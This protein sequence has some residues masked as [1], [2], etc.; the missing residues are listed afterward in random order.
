LLHLTAQ[1]DDHEDFLRQGHAEETRDLWFVSNV[2]DGEKEMNQ[3]NA[4]KEPI[5]VGLDT[6]RY[7]H[8]VT[9]LGQDLQL[10][11][12]PFG[13]CESQEG[14]GQLSEA[15][16]Q[17]AQQYDNVHFHIRIDAAGQYSANLQR[18]LHTLDFPKTIS[19]GEPKRNKDYRNVHFPKRKADAVESHACPRFAVVER[20]KATPETPSEYLQ[21][22]EVLSSLQSQTKRTTRLTNQLH[23]RLS[24]A[25]PELATLVDNLAAPS[26]LN[27]LK[28]YPTA[29]KIAAAQLSSIQ[30]IAYLRKG[31]AQQ[32]YE[33]AKQSTASLQGP[34]IEGII[35]Q[36][37]S[38]LQHSLRA[39]KKLEKLLK[40]AYDALPEGNHIYVKSIPG[41]G[42]LTAAALVASMVSIDRFATP[43]ALVNFYGVFP[44]ENSSGFDKQGKPVPPGTMQM[45]QK[46]NDLVRKLLY[47]ACLS[48]IN[49][50]PALRA[51]YARKKA[52]KKRG[53][54]SLGHCMSKLLHLVFA[55]WKTGKPFD[56]NHYPWAKAVEPEAQQTDTTMADHQNE[57]DRRTEETVAGRKEQSSKRQA[58]TATSPNV[59]PTPTTIKD[60]SSITSQTRA[61]TP[62]MI[63]FVALREQIT[64][65]QALNQLG[66]L[67]HLRGNATQRRGPCPIHRSQRPASRSF[68]VN[69]KRNIFHCFS[70]TCQAHGNVVDLWAT[71][72]NLPLHEAAKHL[73]ATCG[74]PLPT[75]EQKRRGTR[76]QY[77]PTNQD[78]K[79]TKKGVI[80]PD[81]T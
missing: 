12:E 47:M 20:P 60:A 35:D 4:A 14:Y 21:L 22:R 36:L 39:E 13:F 23:N 72:H 64:I 67:K 52:N 76:T 33:A 80:T 9:F 69:L 73:A 79:T 38:E 17:L 61:K 8:H 59:E 10:A 74:V 32:I 43:D 46:G 31:K 57:A 77:D 70:P 25:F 16:N 54:V 34:V 78:A 45:C 71:I 55:V 81:A 28:K 1:T 6:A 11:K 26:L 49:N 48:G 63:D 51:L 7:G 3:S 58:V 5:G 18:F 27:L 41:I 2:T 44:E 68:S 24:R 30:S 65:E 42:K 56:P 66:H 75:K 19:V 40:K 37:V 50:N 53:D 62:V 29:Q 15:F